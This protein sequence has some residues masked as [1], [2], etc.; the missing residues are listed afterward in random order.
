MTKIKHILRWLAVV[1]GALLGAVIVMF[2]VHWVAMYIHHFGT[3]DP[4]ITDDQGRGLLQSMPLESLER[5]GDALFVSGTLI[6]VGAFIAPRFHF[7]TAIVLTLL[8]VGLISWAFVSAGSM[9]M[10]I[11]DSPFRMVITAILWLVSVGLALSYARGLDK[12]A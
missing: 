12:G 6:G 4:I 8:L 11:D 5:F 1:P 7:A 2:P 9:G 10:H 3:P